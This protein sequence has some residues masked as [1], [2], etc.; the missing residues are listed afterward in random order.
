MP[1]VAEAIAFVRD[2]RTS[3]EQLRRASQLLSLEDS[4]D[5]EVVRARLL[6]YLDALDREASVVCLNPKVFT[7]ESA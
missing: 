5:A 2:S 7:P 4:T 6:A 1:S 3:P